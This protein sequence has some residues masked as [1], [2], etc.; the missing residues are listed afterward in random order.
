MQQQS[1]NKQQQPGSIERCFVISRSWPKDNRKELLR[2]TCGLFLAQQVLKRVALE[3]NHGAMLANRSEPIFGYN[4]DLSKIEL[5]PNTSATVLCYG[6]DSAKNSI[7]V[8]QLHATVSTGWFATT[9]ERKS[10]LMMV[11]A[12]ENVPLVM[13][14]SSA[15]SAAAAIDIPQPQQ[16]Q[17]RQSMLLTPA[18]LLPSSP[19]TSAGT[20]PRAGAE[21]HQGVSPRNEV[22]KELINRQ[23]GFAVNRAATSANANASAN[24]SAN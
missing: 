8:Y 19:P 13:T 23:L 20:S 15:V 7:R 21:H 5:Q 17:H 11:Y 3:Q 14:L 24:A 4:Y 22:L 1:D 9:V 6:D 18:S 16:Q 12:I 10:E 2:A